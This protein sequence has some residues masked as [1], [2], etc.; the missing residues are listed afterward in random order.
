MDE[1]MSNRKR[2]NYGEAKVQFIACLDKVLEMQKAGYSVRAIYSKLHGEGMITMSYNAF[3]GNIR[4]LD[5]HIK[6]SRKKPL[7]VA[8]IAPHQKPSIQ[9]VTIPP[10]QAGGTDAASQE[11]RRKEFQA[12][13]RHDIAEAEKQL[14]ASPELDKSEHD[15]LSEKLI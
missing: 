1:H 9:T 4:K 6:R 2:L 13:M 5:T 3:H 15:K 11:Q 8:E 14:T 12:A 7:T 10:A